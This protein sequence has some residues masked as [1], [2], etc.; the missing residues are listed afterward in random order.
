MNHQQTGRLR[1]SPAVT[2]TGIDHV[3]LAY[4]YLDSDDV[5]GYGSLLDENVSLDRPDIPPARGRAEVIR[6][7]LDRVVPRAHHRIERIVAEGDSVVAV[8]RLSQE[9]GARSYDRRG[10]GFVDVFTL[11]DEGMLLGCRRYYFTSPG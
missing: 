10:V 9:S 3:R 2:A 4:D 8:G 6:M 5:D 1:L 11:S 7:H